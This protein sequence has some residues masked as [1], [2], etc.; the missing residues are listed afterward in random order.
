[1]R[2]A[3][4]LSV[5]GLVIVGILAGCGPPSEV[6]PTKRVFIRGTYLDENGDPL[7]DTEIGL[8][9]LDF[10]NIYLN[11]WWYP[12]P[13]YKEWTDAEGSY[14]FEAMGSEFIWEATGTAKY[15]IIANTDSLEGPVTAMG[16]FVIHQEAD[17]PDADLWM[18][19]VEPTIENDTAT[20]NW[21]AID[22]LIGEAPDRYGFSARYAYWDLWR[23]DT[24]TQGFSLPTYVFQN[25]AGAWRVHATVERP[26]DEGIDWSYHSETYA[27]TNVLPNSDHTLLSK[28]DNAFVNDDTTTS[29]TTLTDQIF[30]QLVNFENSHPTSVMLDLGDTATINS[31]VV[32]GLNTGYPSQ[33][34]SFEAFHVYVTDDMTDWG[35]SVATVSRESGYLRFDF[36]PV[37]GRYVKVEPNQG[38]NIQINWIKEIAAFGPVE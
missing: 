29:Y 27:G 19:N 9:I 18:A 4:L 25:V 14:E 26:D 15:V 35:E 1:M 6:D 33:A 22:A 20:F 36:D 12:A 7:V 28:N 38:S 24:V 31:F 32:Y 5:A 17:M 21:D 11:N 37:V 2:K 3:V 34:H 30:H 8:W 16:F 10:T 23:E 13:T